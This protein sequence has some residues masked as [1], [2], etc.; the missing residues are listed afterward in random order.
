MGVL[1]AV[2]IVVPLMVPIYAKDTPALAGFPFFYW[3]QFVMI[4]VVSILTY[5]AFRLVA[6]RRPTGR[7][8]AT[9]PPAG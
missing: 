7:V 8:P 3:F 2:A 6:R 1:L 5:A 9:R 4:P